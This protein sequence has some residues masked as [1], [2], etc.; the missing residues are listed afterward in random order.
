MSSTCS[1]PR[2]S[3]LAK[4]LTETSLIFWDESVM[5][6][7]HA[8]EAVSRT[9]QDLRDEEDPRRE[10]PFGGITVCFCGDFRQILPVVKKGTRGMIVSTSLRRSPLWQEMNVLRLRDNMRLQRPGPSDLERTAIHTFAQ[11]LLYV[12]GHV[13]PDKCIYWDPRDQVINSSVEAL[14]TE[15]YPDLSQRLLSLDL[16]KGRAILA[17]KNEQVAEVNTILLSAM[18]GIEHALLSADKAGADMV[19]PDELLHSLAPPELPP[20]KLQ[21]KVGA[22]V[23]LLR[24]LNPSYGLFNG[25]RL[26]VEAI[27]R[28]RIS[29][30][31]LGT[32][33]HGNQVQL[34][35]IPQAAAKADEVQFTRLQFPV[36]LAFAMTINKAQGQS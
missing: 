24:N 30:K 1:I 3:D 4:L 5:A 9:L 16:L 23:I 25:T 11:Q 20:R 29:C 35:R 18:P 15:V 27:S 32:L 26:R 10:R 34:P 12:G 13:D 14:A 28:Y 31:I 22:V 17:P 36:K 7:R 19:Y 33:H 21:L 8:I 6:H 2:Q